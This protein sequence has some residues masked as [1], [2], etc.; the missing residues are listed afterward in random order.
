MAPFVNGS[1]SWNIA[2][3]HAQ[4]I[5]IAIYTLG[6]VP[7]SCKQNYDALFGSRVHVLGASLTVVDEV[8]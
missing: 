7:A 1:V 8:F 3:H 5:G 4:D 6:R 2:L